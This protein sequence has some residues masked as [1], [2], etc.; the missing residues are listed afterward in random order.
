MEQVA[1]IASGGSSAANRKEAVGR[2][3]QEQQWGLQLKP[4]GAVGSGSGS[5]PVARWTQTT[6]AAASLTS[7]RPFR[8]S[9]RSPL[10][11]EEVMRQRHAFVRAEEKGYVQLQT[12]H[13]TLI[14]SYTPTSA[15]APAASSRRS[16]AA[17]GRTVFHRSSA[18]S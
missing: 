9:A 14:S 11:E 13:G 5:V 6:A 16:V 4:T 2:P 7:L 1:G 12:S 3:R 18:T 10:S 8:L 15:L 17:T